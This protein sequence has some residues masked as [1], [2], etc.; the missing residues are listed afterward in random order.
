VNIENT[1]LLVSIVK[2]VLCFYFATKAITRTTASGATATTMAVVNEDSNNAKGG[3][4]AGAAA[5]TGTGTACDTWDMIADP[6]AE[7]LDAPKLDQQ[8][9]ISIEDMPVLS[10]SILTEEKAVTPL[11]TPQEEVKEEMKEEVQV[12]VEVEVVK[13]EQPIEMTEPCELPVKEE[14]VP[15]LSDVEFGVE[16]DPVVSQP[17]KRSRNIHHTTTNN[18][19]Y[20]SPP[21]VTTRFQLLLKKGGYHCPLTDSTTRFHLMVKRVAGDYQQENIRWDLENCR[22]AMCMQPPKRVIHSRFGNSY[23]GRR[24]LMVLAT[25]SSSR[26]DSNRGMMTQDN[27]VEDDD[28][29]EKVSKTEAEDKEGSMPAATPV[30]MPSSSLFTVLSSSITSSVHSFGL[31]GSPNNGPS[32]EMDSAP[33]EEAVPVLNNTS[34]CVLA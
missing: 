11:T 21:P 31:R 2:S 4:Q 19:S 17:R 20:S 23:L 12:E 22:A 33:Y 34:S 25:G 9:S 14:T 16:V 8:N 15:T 18:G 27:P 13:V 5:L 24:T 7:Q 3:G 29:E 26:R 28:E 10:P 30:P 1:L 32:T 6:R